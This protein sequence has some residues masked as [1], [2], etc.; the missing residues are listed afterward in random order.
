M[1]NGFQTID[2]AGLWGGRLFL[3]NSL[4]STNRRAMD[5]LPEYRS[6]DVISATAQTAGRGR[7]SRSWLSPADRGL[8]LSVVLRPPHLAPELISATGF[9]AA[10]AVLD[11]L[12]AFNIEA[13]LKWPNDVIVGGRKISGILAELDAASQTVV[14]GMGLNVNLTKADLQASN[15][16]DTATSML[17]SRN[18]EFDLADVRSKLISRL[19]T[20]FEKARHKGFSWIAN[21]WARHDWLTGHEV[22]IEAGNGAVRGVYSGMDDTGALCLADSS[23]AR[24]TFTAGDVVRLHTFT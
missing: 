5:A 6:G 2:D 20:T 10:L 19:Q 22:R 23:G 11:S 12:A 9:V 4:P 8:T 14:L 1:K 15:L 3:F 24:H 16:A 13:M 17:I 7:F 21:D 18:R